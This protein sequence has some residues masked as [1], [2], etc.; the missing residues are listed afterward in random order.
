[1]WAWSRST[2]SMGHSQKSASLSRTTRE[3]IQY[4]MVRMH[5]RARF[6]F[7][8]YTYVYGKQFNL[9]G[10]FSCTY[11]YP[12]RCVRQFSQRTEARRNSATIRGYAR[13]RPCINAVVWNIPFCQIWLWFFHHSHSFPQSSCLCWSLR[14]V[15][16]YIYAPSFSSPLLMQSYFSFNKE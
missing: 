6:F 4:A 13:I 10:P 5:W 1:M 8:R 7:P 9:R 11:Y 2:D 16:D 15:T 3:R 14:V 12:K